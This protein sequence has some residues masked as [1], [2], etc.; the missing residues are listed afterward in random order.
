M[1]LADK[2]KKAAGLFIQFEET[3]E[4]TPQAPSPSPAPETPASVDDIDKRLAA[5]S[6]EMAGLGAAPSETK[7]VAQVVQQSP[8]PNLDEIK[9]DAGA[10]PPPLPGAQTLDFAAL[11][12]AANLP[13]APFTAEQTLEMLAKLPANL[14][15]DVKR[16]TMSVTLNAMGTAIGASAENIVADASRKLA[17][18][19]AYAADV[20]K[21]TD[22][23]LVAAETEIQRLTTEIEQRRQAVL[24]ARE[25]QQTIHNLCDAE[26]DRLDD[27]LEFFSLDIGPS[28][29]AT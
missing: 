25:K 29:H 13:P 26:A 21:T 7:T 11:Y 17:A 1:P 16:Q 12:A 27:V 10:V 23:Y 8:G 2:L 6:A 4:E 19:A 3:T 5:M 14:P 9:V 24:N 15:L 28:K 22:A 18:L 20:D